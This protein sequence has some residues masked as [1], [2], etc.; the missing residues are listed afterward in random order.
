VIFPSKCI[1][2]G[3]GGVELCDAC[4]GRLVW[5]VQ[6]CPECGK[7]SIGGWAHERCRRKLGLDGV[8]SLYKYDKLMQEI[9]K[10]VKYRF[11]RDLLRLCM[12][13]DGPEPVF[14]D[15]DVVVPTPLHKR[16]ENWRGFN[17]AEELGKV[18]VELWDLPM[19]RLLL[20]RRMTK[21]VAEM[22]RAEERKKELGGAFVLDANKGV[23]GKR[24]LLIDDV[25]TSGATMGEM[26]RVL[27]KNG[28]VW[29][30]GWAL[31]S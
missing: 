27:K 7:D 8:F 22:D 28:A 4:R 30:G 11:R 15:I 20:R 3:A 5:A 16:R 1:N 23:A 17:Q 31:A 21:P 2:C 25:F 9:V 18:L 14:R 29:V 24:I 6:K 19:E 13:K 26:T 10:A 12:P